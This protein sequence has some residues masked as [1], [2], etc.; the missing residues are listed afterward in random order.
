MTPRVA[1]VGD[2][3]VEDGDGRRLVVADRVAILQRPAEGRD[4]REAG[5]L[6]EKAPDLQVG[7]LPGLDL[8]E[9]LHDEALVEHQRAVALVGAGDVNLEGRAVGACRATQAPECGHGVADQRG[10]ALDPPTLGD[11]IEQMR[12]ERRHDRRLVEDGLDVAAGPAQHGHDGRRHVADQRVGVVS[13][14][15]AE[16]DDVGVRFAFGIGHR[17]ERHRHALGQRHRGRDAHGGDLAPLARVPAPRS[18]PR[19]QDSLQPGAVSAGEHRFPRTADGH[20]GGD[21]ARRRCVSAVSL[22]R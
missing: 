3:L 15:D 4:V 8:A 14:G 12:P 18:Q 16:G 21:P 7:V 9:E 19:A 10:I 1:L 17:Q 22:E 11:D 5:P 2:E 6:G 13:F 20:G